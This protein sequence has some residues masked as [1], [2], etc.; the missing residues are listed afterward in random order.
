MGRCPAPAAAAEPRPRST[1]TATTRSGRNA[2][3]RRPAMVAL[4]RRAM[5]VVH[6]PGHKTWSM[7][8]ATEF[9]LRPRDGRDLGSFADVQA[10]LR[11]VFP[12]IEF[13][14]TTSG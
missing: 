8:M 11:R 7:H 9:S 2:I 6:R 1:A 10:L 5:P 13:G 14:W 12:R 3:G 4:V